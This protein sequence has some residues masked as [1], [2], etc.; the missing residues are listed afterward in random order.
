MLLCPDV[1][2]AQVYGPSSARRGGDVEVRCSTFGLKQPEEQV[3]VY[4]CKDGLAVAREESSSL[5]TTFRVKNVRT[6]QVGNY[7][8]VFSR[9]KY[10]P[11]QVRG[12]GK[13]SISIQVFGK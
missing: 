5:D 4:L 8:C 9:M 6:E 12:H 10:H 3:Y 1:V 7:S 11:S 2:P 13:N